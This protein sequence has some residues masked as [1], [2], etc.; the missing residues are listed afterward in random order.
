MGGGNIYDI[1]RALVSETICLVAVPAF[2][3]ISGYLFYQKLQIWDWSIW[4]DKVHK[5]I[6]TLLVP[7]LVWSIIRWTFNFIT[8]NAIT[9]RHGGTWS[10]VLLWIR[11]N[12]SI[13]MIWHDKLT[14]IHYINWL[15]EVYA[16]SA[17]IHT[18]FWFI[19]DLIVMVIIS[20][21]IACFFRNRLSANVYMLILFAA[22]I[23]MIW[24]VLPGLSIKAVFFYSLGGY[25]A[26]GYGRNIIRWFINIPL[27]NATL[28]VILTIMMVCSYQNWQ[29]RSILYPW[30]ILSTL[31]VLYKVTFNFTQ[32]GYSFPSLLTDSC[33]FIFAFHMFVL[34][35]KGLF[36]DLFDIPKP[37]TSLSLIVWYFLNPTIAVACS[38]FCFYLLKR[39]MP[40][41]CYMLTGQK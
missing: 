28:F 19:R 33:F 35:S 29:Y 34:I 12:T 27:V 40:G 6:F 20:P 36:M 38:V 22:F 17:P 41:L 21:M 23:S 10:S 7:Y 5:R 8:T 1:L 32:K 4:K 37:E 13:M 18:P 24:P 30:F 15:G 31:V 39:Y 9:L 25:I 16:N 14:D 26:Y 11:E 2:F 3:L